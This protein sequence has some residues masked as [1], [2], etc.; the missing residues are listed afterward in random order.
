MPNDKLQQQL[1]QT[2]DQ[3]AEQLDAATLS[4]LNQGRQKA[5]D[6]GLS[7]KWSWQPDRWVRSATVFASITAL[8]VCIDLFIPSG[9]SGTTAPFDDMQMLSAGED[10]EL[11]EELQFYQWLATQ[12]Q[13]G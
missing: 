7:S 2:L 13:A 12:E 4:R 3:Q 1:Q 10:I 5:L 8:A 6:Q 9:D 11:Y